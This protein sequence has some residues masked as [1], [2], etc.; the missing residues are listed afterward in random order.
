MVHCIIVRDF[1]LDNA[2]SLAFDE[3]WAHNVDI[4]A[5]TYICSVLFL[6]YGKGRGSRTE[7]EEEAINR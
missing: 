7:E 2:L 1:E 4:Y 5:Y 3:S 6:W